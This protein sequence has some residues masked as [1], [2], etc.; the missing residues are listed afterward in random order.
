VKAATQHCYDAKDFVL[1]N[2]TISL[3]SK[4]HGQL[5]AAIQSMIELAMGWLASIKTEHGDKKWLEL[6]ETLRSVTEGKVNPC[7]MKTNI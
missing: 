4:K 7:L 1:L 5:K 6:V 3:L 2:S